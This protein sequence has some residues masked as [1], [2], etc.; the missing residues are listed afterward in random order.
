MFKLTEGAYINSHELPSGDLKHYAITL[1]E[2]G[3]PVIFVISE[4]ESKTDI[5]SAVHEVKA[6]GARIIAVP[7]KDNKEFDDFIKVPDGGE[8]SAIINI[9]PLQLLAYYMAD[10]LK[11]N[12]NKPRNIAKSVTVK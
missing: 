5:L 11:N 6:R 2:P 4:D 8:A 7:Q 9:V 3:K 1:I 10:F 12:V